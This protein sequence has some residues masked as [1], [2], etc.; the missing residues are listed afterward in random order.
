M[1]LD[2]LLRSLYQNSIKFFNEI[3]V[4]YKTS[5][6]LH[7]KSYKILQNRFPN[8]LFYRESFFSSLKKNLIKTLK[9]N[10][11]YI[12][13]MTDDDILFDKLFE[14][15]KFEI[16]N[17]MKE[18]SLA[19]FSIRL[20]TNCIYSHPANKFFEIKNYQIVKNKYL[21]WDWTKQMEGD[22]NYPL[23]LDG[24]LFSKKQIL[25]F[26][27]NFKGNPNH[28]ESHLQKFNNVISPNM[29]SF[30]KSKLVG[31]PINRV[32]KYSSNYYGKNYYYSP[33]ELALRYINDEEI[34]LFSMDFSRIIGAH[35]EL[36][37]IFKKRHNS[38][39]Q[40]EF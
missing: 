4:I 22:F 25:S 20:G 38:T 16:I 9:S 6:N 21:V 17:L 24:H 35:Q 18:Y 40:F 29:A 39:I 31:I 3:V 28:L 33:D 15:D 2:A 23:S 36:N 19:T 1:Q 8:I 12:M 32:S 34:D 37:L 10:F 14:L 11:D 26:L 30:I 5:N 13:F 7:R 27:D